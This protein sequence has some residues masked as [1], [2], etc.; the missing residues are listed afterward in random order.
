M[1]SKPEQ[2]SILA[3]AAWLLD[4]VHVISFTAL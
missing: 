2:D 1:A 4:F 3:Q